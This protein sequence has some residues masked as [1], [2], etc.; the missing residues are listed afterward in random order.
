MCSIQLVFKPWY[1]AIQGQENKFKYVKKFILSIL[2]KQTKIKIWQTLW[3][4]WGRILW[5][6]IAV[7]E[8]ICI[9]CLTYDTNTIFITT[10][11]WV[12][13]LILIFRLYVTVKSSKDNLMKMISD[14][15]YMLLKITL[16]YIFKL[17]V[18]GFAT[19][20]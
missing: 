13:Y 20:G 14:S 5:N 3:N 15:K 16:H 8:P 10:L 18:K 2:C 6:D 7:M 19:M 4:I 12:W 11:C 9:L 1:G 17:L